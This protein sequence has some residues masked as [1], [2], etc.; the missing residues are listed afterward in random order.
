[1]QLDELTLVL[2]TRNE[3]N[4]IARFLASIPF[5]LQLIV[6]DASD[7][8][9][10]AVIAALRPDNTYVLQHPG[11]VTEARQLASEHARTEWLLFADADIEYPANYFE[12]LAVLADADVFYGPKLSHDEFV[13]YYRWFAR[14]QRLC[15]KVGIPAATG[16][17]LLMRR[18]ALLA[19]GGF[20][21]DLTCNEDS[22]LVWRLKRRGFKTRFEPRLVVYATDHRRLRRGRMRKTIHSLLR[23]ILLFTDLMPVRWRRHDWGY[24]SSTASDKQSRS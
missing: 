13:K 1:M 4:N 2:P 15:D 8:E 22:E 17:N 16:S 14:G 19:A 7:D 24:W 3:A 10:R 6:V 12:Q 11:S 21:L 23:C 20:D 5:N 18:K 9:T